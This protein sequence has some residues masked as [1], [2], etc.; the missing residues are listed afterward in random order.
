MSRCRIRDSGIAMTDSNDSLLPFP[1]LTSG[2]RL[3]LEINGYVVVE[4]TLTNDGV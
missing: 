3:F 4:N 1:A 2:Q